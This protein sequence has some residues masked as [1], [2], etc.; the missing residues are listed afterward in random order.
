MDKNALFE[1]WLKTMLAENT[2]DAMSKLFLLK[3]F[4]F[5][6]NCGYIQ[7][8]TELNQFAQNQIQAMLLEIESE[9]HKNNAS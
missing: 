3:A 8:N 1:N 2:I 9:Q 5:G 7:S 6:F 4:E